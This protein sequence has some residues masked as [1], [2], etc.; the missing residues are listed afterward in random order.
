M[1][2]GM[3]EVPDVNSFMLDFDHVDVGPTSFAKG[4]N[5]GHDLF[6]ARGERAEVDG[7][8][9]IQGRFGY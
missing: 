9:R 4:G 7:G 6:D 3:R 1:Y 8:V 5:G 2:N